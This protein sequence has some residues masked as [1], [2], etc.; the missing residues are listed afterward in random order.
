MLGNTLPLKQWTT[1]FCTGWFPV[2]CKVQVA[3]GLH[4]P[5][6]TD[7]TVKTTDSLG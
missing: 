7:Q 6:V 3:V 5:A 1:S 4:G 2:E